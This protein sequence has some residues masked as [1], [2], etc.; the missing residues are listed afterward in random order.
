MKTDSPAIETSEVED[1]EDSSSSASSSAL[2]S[3][4]VEGRIF[5]VNVEIVSVEPSWVTRASRVYDATSSGA[6]GIIANADPVAENNDG[7]PPPPLN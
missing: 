3:S 1:E 5:M 2:S 7:I 4:A 6:E